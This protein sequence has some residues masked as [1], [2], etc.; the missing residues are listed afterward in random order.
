MN[1]ELSL[2]KASPKPI[3]TSW[4]EDK[5]DELAQSIEEQG[6]IV[7]IK[8]R[9]T[10]N[11]HYEIVYGHR[12]L[13]A[14]RIAGFTET[15]A[16]VEGIDNTDALLQAGM[17]NLS[18]EDM[19]A[20]DKGAW[21]DWIQSKTGWNSRELERR[22]GINQALL[23][24]WKT[25]YEESVEGTASAGIRQTIEI[26]KAL[27]DPVDKR[28]VAGK[29]DEEGLTW[30]QTKQ[31]AESVAATEDPMMR[32]QLINAPYSPYTHDPEYAKERADKY[33]SHDPMA[34][35]K[36]PPLDEA[37][38]LTAEV[39]MIVDFIKKSR[40]MYE[41]VIKMDDLGK[42]SPEARPFIVGKLKAQTRL[43]EQVIDH[44][45]ESND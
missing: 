38:R 11:E 29:V 17:E 16:I 6:L 8:V 39:S 20:Y 32:E 23:Y 33:G 15:D 35:D 26:K 22:S 45:E 37:W 13:E 41:E 31:V 36:T 18:K 43:I 10:D 4:D 44:L 14:M 34:Q 3:R 24:E 2:I 1:I 28:A 12:R 27:T 42:F 19:S 30:R 5:L 9:P 21:V 40:Q 25:Y 7:P